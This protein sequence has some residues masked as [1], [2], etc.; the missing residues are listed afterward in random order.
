[1]IIFSTNGSKAI[2]IH[3]IKQ[4][5]NLNFTHRAQ[6]A[7]KWITDLSVKHRIVNLLEEN[8]GENF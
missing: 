8:I 1:M 7:S 3:K 5:L 6:I 2:I 4:K